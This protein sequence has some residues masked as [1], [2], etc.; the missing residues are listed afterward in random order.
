MFTMRPVTFDDLPLILEWRN[1]PEIREKMFT[2]HEISPEEHYSYFE[3]SLDDPTREHFLCVTEDDVPVG[4]VNFHQID[5]LN[6]NAFWGFYSGDPTRRG[7]GTQMG[8]LALNHAFG[9]LNLHKLM[10]EVLSTNA[11][12]L[13]F[14]EKLGFHTEGVFRDMILTPAGYVNVHRLTIFKDEW[15]SEWRQKCETR[16]RR[17]SNFA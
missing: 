13:E 9:A 5:L 6:R 7:I 8:F 16:L 14:H 11:P 4:V 17:F 10:G 3:R 2:T 1:R 15:E 12:S